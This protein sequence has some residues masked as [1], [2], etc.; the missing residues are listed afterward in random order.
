MAN[1]DERFDWSTLST[2]PPPHFAVSP[3]DKITES[4]AALQVSK[5]QTAVELFT[6]AAELEQAGNISQAID[7]YS[8]SFRLDPDVEKYVTPAEGPK[9]PP[10]SGEKTAR[11]IQPLNV[12]RIAE[13]MARGP[14]P[15]NALFPR[16]PSP[17]LALPGHILLRIAAWLGVLHAGSLENLAQ[18]C[19]KCYLLCRNDAL[20][21]QLCLAVDARTP[22]L[23]PRT[24][25][26]Y[27]LLYIYR[28]RLRTDGLYICRIRYFR[29]GASESISAVSFNQ[30]IHLITY[31]RYLR[32]WGAPDGH[33]CISFVT[34]EAPKKSVIDKL[35]NPPEPGQEAIG[36]CIGWYTR[37]PPNQ[38]PDDRDWT[39]YLH[40]PNQHCKVDAELSLRS[41]A[42][43]VPTNALPHPR[44]LH[45]LA[46]VDYR[47]HVDRLHRV[48]RGPPQRHPLPAFEDEPADD[49]IVYDTSNWGKF[50][51][52]K[53]R[54]YH[55]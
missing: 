53:V 55:S 9:Q 16:T 7:L 27:R 40:D 34:T 28:S 50:I 20:W 30:P 26:P 21:R 4:L 35:R 42:N 24:A 6:E 19:R 10:P 3:M 46:C 48:A 43:A 15:E 12:E 29:P 8:K 22:P 39:L 32:F 5:R 18:A 38:S 25:T 44:P 33:R 52:S 17:L 45:A 31:Y 23:L 54:S 1:P 41:A 47:G 51:F 36:M 11:L 14:K 13:M 2:T 49:E 37:K